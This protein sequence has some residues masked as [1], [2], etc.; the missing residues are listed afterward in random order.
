MKLLIQLYVVFIASLVSLPIVPA[1]KVI[2]YLFNDG[3]SQQGL[4]CSA[5]EIQKI[6]TIF[7]V[8]NAPS[9]L[10][11]RNVELTERVLQAKSDSIYQLDFDAVDFSSEEDSSYHGPKCLDNCVGYHNDHC[12]ATRVKGLRRDL[13][14]KLASRDDQSRGLQLS[15][16][17]SEKIAFDDFQATYPANCKTKCAGQVDNNCMGVPGC[18]GYRRDLAVSKEGERDLVSFLSYNSSDPNEF[19]QPAGIYPANCKTKCAG[20]VDNNCMGVPGCQGYRRY[21]E[22]RSRIEAAG[23]ATPAPS[24][25]VD[26]DTVVP[27]AYGRT[28]PP[29]CRERCRGFPVGRCLE[30]GCEG[31]RRVLANVNDEKERDLQKLRANF[32]AVS[33]SSQQTYPP[34]CKTL[35]AGQ[36][37][38]QCKGVAGCQGYRRT[39]SVNKFVNPPPEDWCVK[40][41]QAID[42]QLDNLLRQVSPQCRALIQAPRRKECYNDA[43]LCGA[44]K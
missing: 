41:S 33:E 14:D 2:R 27:P 43:A 37:D 19:L 15:Y 17:A 34:K 28:Y 7:E 42:Q 8:F 16:N 31:Y 18:Q 24:V 25:P 32:T 35:C 3:I 13:E 21:L 22:D 5:D 26:D 10:R 20:Q 29:Y 6:A 44:S 23:S 1:E 30:Q 9:K 36:A 11:K 4:E 12:F 40:A 39:L 38:S